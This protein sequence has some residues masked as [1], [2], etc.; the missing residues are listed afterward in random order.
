V[1][2]LEDRSA[3]LEVDVTNVGRRPV[4]LL[5]LIPA[6]GLRV[7][8][9][10]G[11]EDRLPVVLPPQTGR[12]P[13][14]RTLEVRVVVLCGAL[15]GADLLAPFEQVSAI[16]EAEDRSAITS[17]EQLSSDPDGQLRQLAGRTCRRADARRRPGT[18]WRRQPPPP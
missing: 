14:V 18:G 16:V 2:R 9:V 1:V 17:V 11:V 15:L 6:R 3:V 13:V 12:R 5:S 10:D 4:R 7:L 8:T